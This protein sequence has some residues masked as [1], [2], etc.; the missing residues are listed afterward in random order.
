MRTYGAIALISILSISS[1]LAQPTASQEPAPK[2]AFDGDKSGGWLFPVENLND[3]LP[4]WLRF[5]GALA[6]K[7]TMA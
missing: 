5:G 1:A 2:N 4:R 7:A 6:S 3:T